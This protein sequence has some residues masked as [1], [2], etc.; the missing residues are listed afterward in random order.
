MFLTAIVFILILGLLIFVHEAGHFLAARAAGIKV[1]EFAFGFPPRLWSVVRGGT[2]YALNLL[3][4]G[5]YVKLLGEDGQ[6]DDPR[7]F[8]R[9]KARVRLAIIVAGVGMN[10]VLAVVALW[11]G[12]MIGMVPVVSDPV[13]LGGVQAPQVMITY[14]ANGSPAAGASLTPGDILTDF[15]TPEAVRDFTTR[16]AGQ[17]IQLHIIH[18]GD[19]VTKSVTLASGTDS[20]LGIGLVQLTKVKLDPIQAL[21]A[22]TLET[23]K[24]VQATFTFL[25]KFFVRL[26]TTGQVAE[27]VSGPVGIFS[28]TGQAVAL[29]FSYVLQLLAILSVNLALLNILPFPALDGGRALFVGLEGITR[30]K[31]VRDEIEATIHAVGFVLLLILVALVTYRDI[32]N[33]R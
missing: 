9:Q 22:A 10:L 7:S 19:R 28:V 33:L 20:P 27:G 29:G 3:P 5:G 8:G 31:V 23:G 15:T 30:R 32:L 2:R 18:H 26:F 6:S 12:F 11:I 16:Q 17:T 4:L 24:T 1:E 25:A 13:T 14:V 21:G